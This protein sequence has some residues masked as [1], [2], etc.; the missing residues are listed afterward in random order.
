M[1]DRRIGF[2]RKTVFPD[3]EANGIAD[4]ASASYARADFNAEHLDVLHMLDVCRLH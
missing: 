3:H 4:R 1:A 2:P